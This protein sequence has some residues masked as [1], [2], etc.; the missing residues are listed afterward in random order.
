MGNSDFHFKLR[1]RA[2]HRIDQIPIVISSLPVQFVW[3]ESWHGLVLHIIEDCS[4]QTK[5][6]SQSIQFIDAIFI[7]LFEFERNAKKVH[8][9]PDFLSCCSSSS[10]ESSFFQVKRAIL[11]VLE[12]PFFFFYF[13]GAK[14]NKQNKQNGSAERSAAS[15]WLDCPPLGLSLSSRAPREVIGTWQE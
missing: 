11:A 15:F 12:E 8:F 5:K 4:T 13:S 9:H 6:K 14:K 1:A 7:F 3:L 10:W 2:F